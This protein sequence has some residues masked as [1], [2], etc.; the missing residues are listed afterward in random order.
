MRNAA[1]TALLGASRLA[2]HYLRY[3]FTG[4]V[5]GAWGDLCD[6]GGMLSNLARRKGPPVTRE[7][8]IVS[9]FE[10]VRRTAR[11]H[12]S[13]DRGNVHIIREEFVKINSRG[14]RELITGQRSENTDCVQPRKASPQSQTRPFRYQAWNRRNGKS[15]GRSRYPRKERSSPRA[16]PL[17]PKSRIVKRGRSPP[18]DEKGGPRKAAVISSEK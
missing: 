14:R 15:K 1:K 2:R 17:A 4:E 6:M 5:A 16:S 7:R 3:L 18:T 8:E 10:K 13:R 9:R 12:L 11:V